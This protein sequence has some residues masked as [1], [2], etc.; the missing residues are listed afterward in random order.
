LNALQSAGSEVAALLRGAWRHKPP[1]PDLN[2][3]PFAGTV[4]LLLKSGAGA[5]GWWRIQ[6]SS[7][8][9][10]PEA[11]LLHDA[12]LEYAV[13]ALEYERKLATLVEALNQEKLNF[14]LL[15]GCATSR[16]YPESNLRPSGDIDVYMPRHEWIRI[17]EILDQPQYRGYRVDWEH[18]EFERFD[19]RSFEEF[20]RH[21]ESIWVA[22]VKVKVL[23]PEDHLR[24]L[25]LHLL[26]HGGWRPVWL[27]DVAAVLEQLPETFDWGR[28]LGS[29]EM[30]AGWILCTIGLARDIL[31]AEPIN[32]PPRLQ[33]LSLPQW[34][35]DSL[36]ERWGESSSPSL[37][38]F[39]EE[40]R[41]SWWRPTWLIGALW[42]RWPNPI[43]ATIDA[44]GP[45]D[46]ATRLPFQLKNC[47]SRAVELGRRILAENFGSYSD[48]IGGK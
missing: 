18:A 6:H 26:K 14:I 25:C 15:K 10:L 12:Y 31:Q 44:D 4:R 43:Q 8:C 23:G 1:S 38:F 47:R 34:L 36:L 29:N 19:V 42:K 33:N 30:Q 22:G 48:G 45:F 13:Q 35:V 46:E 5:L 7:L 40:A 9:W 28:C 21:T 16:F 20:Y 39:H 37:P 2:L 11:R 17:R 27:C 24:F 41:Q 3:A 32:P